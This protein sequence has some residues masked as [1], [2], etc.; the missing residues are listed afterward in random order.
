[1]K[2]TRKAVSALVALS[3]VGGIMLPVAPAFAYSKNS[4][5]KVVSIANDDVM[6]P[7]GDITIR[8]DSDYSSHFKAG[9]VF[10]LTL[11]SGVEWDKSVTGQTYQVDNGDIKNFTVSYT[12]DQKMEVKMPAGIGTS[13]VDQIFL[14]DLK[15]KADS[16]V[17]GDIKVKIDGKDSAVDDQELVIARSLDGDSVTIAESVE[18]IGDAG[19]GGTI[20]IEEAAVGSMYNGTQKQTVKLKLPSDFEWQNSGGTYVST[21]DGSSPTIVFGGGFASVT[22]YDAKVDGRNLEITF[23]APNTNNAQRGSITVQTMINA[24]KDADYGDVEVNVS[25]TKITD[26]D[27]V[28]AKYADFGVDLEVK[29]VKQLLAGRFDEETEKITIEESVPNTLVNGRKFRIE[30]PTW[31]KISDVKF[32]AGSTYLTNQD[33]DDNEVEWTVQNV[34][35]SSTSTVKIEMKFK[36][37]IQGDQSGDITATVSGS[38]GAKGDLVVAKAIKPVDIEG[39]KANVKIG[40]KKQALNDIIITEND[41]EAIAEKDAYND[42]KGQLVVKLPDNVN[43]N[44]YK[45][46]VIEGNLEIDED[47]VDTGDT[48]NLLLIPIKSESSKASKIKISG[49]TVDIDRTV[50]EGDIVAKVQ[51]NAVAQNAKSAKGWDLVD[52]DGPQSITTADG[53][54]VTGNTDTLD[55]AEFNVSAVASAVVATVVT[56]AP[57]AGTVLFNV[58]ST[59]YTAGGVTKVMDA[60]PYIKNGRTYVPVRYLALALGVA[61]DDIAYENGV[62]T[63]TKGT[64][65]IKL[66]MGST[67]L[68]KNDSTVSMDV[69]PETVNGRTM[70]P[71][72]FVAEAFGATVGYANGQVVISY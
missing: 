24:D 43:W 1:M 39:Q 72:R 7:I 44:D 36:L 56:P 46:E 4:V 22:S 58:G 5:S 63:L 66:T 20:T 23:T 47:S 69:A 25:G 18:T 29:E 54:K 8:E 3:L 53:T 55:D 49:I 45:V 57:E 33:I 50:A 16:G 64:D 34:S 11:P 31:V 65:V 40:V 28:V 48:D 9:E 12:S 32:S 61:E 51:G 19:Q 70:L 27:V 2:K 15:I 38:S 60:A 37:S 30:F 10:T 26:A 62:V 13:G 14:N 59:V 52:G 71:A 42:S 6:H 21:T 68:M 17:T 67:S 41:S 35:G